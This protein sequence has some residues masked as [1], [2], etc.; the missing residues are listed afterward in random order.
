MNAQA[1]WTALLAIVVTFVVSAAYAP[2]P[3]VH[4]VHVICLIVALVALLER[5][6]RA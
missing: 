6:G 5:V 3:Q 2:S 1:R 4:K